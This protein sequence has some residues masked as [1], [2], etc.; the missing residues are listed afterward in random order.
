MSGAIINRMTGG[1]PGF[2]QQA[3]Y[4]SEAIAGVVNFVL[5]DHFEGVRIR[6]QGG[7]A[8]EGGE[9]TRLGSLTAGSSF[10][11][12]RGSAMINIAYDKDSGLRS[13][14]RAI[15]TTDTSVAT[16]T[17]GDASILQ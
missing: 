5:K 11:E 17:R 9:D 3:I 7:A 10:A 14:Q 2:L 4:G 13:A 16:M 6:G 1:S 12:D 15:S 8:T